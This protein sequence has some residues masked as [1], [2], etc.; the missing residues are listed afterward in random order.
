M[1]ED[2]LEQDRWVDTLI[3]GERA[4]VDITEGEG[5]GEAE[6]VGEPLIEAIFSGIASAS[7]RVE[8]LNPEAK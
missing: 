4:D 8:L 5:E 1:R 2:V 7:V 6:R 3:D